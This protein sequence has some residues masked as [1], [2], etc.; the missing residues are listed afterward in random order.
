[1]PIKFRCPEC[2][3]RLAAPRA[4]AGR[5]IDCGACGARIGVPADLGDD[6]DEPDYAPRA[7]IAPADA[8][9]AAGG[10]TLLQISLGLYVLNVLVQAGTSAARLAL[11]GAQQMMQ[12]APGQL[13]ALGIAGAVCGMLIVVPAVVLRAAGYVRCK[14]V[15]RDVE[16]DTVLTLATVGVVGQGIGIICSTIPTLFGGNA[17][18]MPPALLGMLYLGGLVNLIGLGLEFAALYF[19]YRLLADLYGR[20]GGRRVV[21]YLITFGVSVVIGFF[22]ACGFGMA[23]GFAAF[24]GARPAAPGAPPQVN[25]AKVPNGVWIT[26]AVLLALAV[27]VGVAI[28]VQYFQILARAKSGL[29][30]VARESDGSL[31]LNPEA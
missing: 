20:G 7:D 4:D 28:V 30:A 25:F 23:I 21:V 19:F 2:G 26:G 3:E 17:A 24:A 6:Y 12:P 13:D 11:V 9:R 1:M 22:A 8:A 27:A 5:P 16:A 10:I 29:L 31:D 15:G 14:P 18:Q